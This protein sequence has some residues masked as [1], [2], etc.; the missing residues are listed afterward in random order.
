ML[1]CWGARLVECWS[2]GVLQCWRAGALDVAI[3]I[4]GTMTL[5]VALITVVTVMPRARSIAIATVISSAIAIHAS[6]SVAPPG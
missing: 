1:E 6:V 3:A 5:D 2:A 4:K